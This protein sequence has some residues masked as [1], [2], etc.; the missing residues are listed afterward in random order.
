[1]KYLYGHESQE[2][3]YVV[4]DYPW[5]FRQRTTIRYWIESKEGFGQRFCSQ[6]IN[7]KTGEWCKPKCGVY[8]ALLVMFL[9][10]NGHVKNDGVSLYR[11]KEPFLEF[12][13]T[14]R[15]NM[16]EFQKE[17]FKKIA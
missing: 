5:G 12:R 13:N 6:T 16:C 17:V 1:M 3:A 9:D 14:H 11:G 2:T 7:P 10:E 4:E 8:S 15:E